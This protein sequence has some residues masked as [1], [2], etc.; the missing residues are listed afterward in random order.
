MGGKKVPRRGTVPRR[1]HAPWFPPLSAYDSFSPSFVISLERVGREG[2]RSEGREASEERK[3]GKGAF[4]SCAPHT[5]ARVC[6]S[7]LLP[8]RLR[9]R[10]SCLGDRKSEG[11]EKREREKAEEEEEERGSKK[12]RKPQL[13][14]LCLSFIRVLRFHGGC[15]ST[16]EKAKEG[17]E[18]DDERRTLAGERAGKLGALRRCAWSEASNC[19]SVR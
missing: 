6:V 3:G 17:G 8:K 13:F 14:C 9:K 16:G 19:V 7:V 18:G 12:K 5:H 1:R 10:E 11:E 15:F 2:E 4:P